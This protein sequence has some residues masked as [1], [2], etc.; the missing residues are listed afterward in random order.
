[1]LFKKKRKRKKLGL[2]SSRPNDFDYDVNPALGASSPLNRELLQTPPLTSTP[3]RKNN[4]QSVPT[5]HADYNGKSSQGMH[6]WRS[7]D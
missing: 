1:M 2:K 6:V 5:M 7:G 4:P 3:K